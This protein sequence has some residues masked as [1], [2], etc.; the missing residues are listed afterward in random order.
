MKREIQDWEQIFTQDIICDREVN[1]WDMVLMNARTRMKMATNGEGQA[2]PELI[3]VREK[4]SLN[5][6]YINTKLEA[7][8]VKKEPK[9]TEIVSTYLSRLQQGLSKKKIIEETK[10]DDYSSYRMSS[11]MNPINVDASMNIDI[12]TGEKQE[13]GDLLGDSEDS[14]KISAY[15]KPKTE[16]I[17]VKSVDGIRLWQVRAVYG[18]NEG[19]NKK[20]LD[21]DTY[22]FV[23]VTDKKDVQW[24]MPFQCL[25]I[26]TA[27]DDKVLSKL[28]GMKPVKLNRDEPALLKCMSTYKFPKKEWMK[29]QDCTAA[30]LSLIEVLNEQ[31]PNKTEVEKRKEYLRSKIAI[32]KNT[33]GASYQMF[34]IVK[35]A[36]IGKN[37]IRNKKGGMENVID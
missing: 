33:S 30:V 4:N 24:C 19:K 23:I 17:V 26:E 8:K 1:T 20:T 15:K 10:E 11:K 7:L 16:T 6:G 35:L 9:K 37:V 13:K 18:G 12:E 2:R 36:S 32:F 28:T 5:K 27:M 14:N 3:A 21:E 29:W 22:F 34:W 25:P 31:A